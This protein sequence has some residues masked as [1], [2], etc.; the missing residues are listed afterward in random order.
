M[1]Q[2]A[3][4]YPAHRAGRTADL[5]PHIQR[6]ADTLNEA[7]ATITKS[8]ARDSTKQALLIDALVRARQQLAQA[9]HLVA[10]Y[11][12]V[13]GRSQSSVAKS[14]GLSHTQIGNWYHAPLSDDDLIQ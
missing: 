9:E 1:D 10:E 5:L 2:P 13:Q 7:T 14:F 4:H 11:A 8:S 3:E 6:I 12:V